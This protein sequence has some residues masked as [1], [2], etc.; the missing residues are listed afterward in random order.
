MTTALREV[1]R[2]ELP[3]HEAGAFDHGDVDPVTGRVFVAHTKYG[4]VDVIDAETLRVIDVIADCPEGS[5]VLCSP[6][7][8]SVFAASRGSG[9]VLVIDADRLERTKE[10]E[11]G[12]RPNGLAFAEPHNQLLVADVD[13]ADQAARLIDAS[14]GELIVTPLPGRPR[15]A[16]FDESQ[17]MYLVNI[18]DPASLLSISP[19]GV[20]VTS[21]PISSPGPHGLDLDRERHLAFVA[22][23][24]GQVIVVDL[25]AG[26]ELA[27]I[28]ISGEPDA[29]WFNPKR[30]H[31][32]VAVGDP[33]V[34]EIVDVDR[35]SV[36]KTIATERGAH[37]TAFDVRRQRL[38]AFLP[39]SCAA[40]VLEEPK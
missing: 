25:A 13:A 36:I 33:G 32:Y 1:A 39:T 19:A 16:V 15:W 28:S 12:P 2:V 9:R 6:S 38:Y 4:T 24:G 20:I 30:R 35:G 7:Q 18:R 23:D 34:V 3:P 14:S 37:T 21:L 40:A 11:V 31:L 26:R 22:C 29:I 8:R 27:S 10:F 17:D 5:G